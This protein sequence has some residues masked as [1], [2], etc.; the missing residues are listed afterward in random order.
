MKS[1]PS[2]INK[3][4]LVGP[5]LC[6]FTELFMCCYLLDHINSKVISIYIYCIKFNFSLISRII[7][8]EN[9]SLLECIVV[10]GQ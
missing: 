8:R 4:K 9:P 3:I 2:I 6:L 5:F 1:S 10:I 7:Y